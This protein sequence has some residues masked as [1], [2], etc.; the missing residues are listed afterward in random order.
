[1]KLPEGIEF[2]FHEFC[3]KC[4]VCKVEARI[5]DGFYEEASFKVENIVTCEHYELCE[6]LNTAKVMK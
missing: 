1:M 6:M 2:V 3:Y 5:P 4:P